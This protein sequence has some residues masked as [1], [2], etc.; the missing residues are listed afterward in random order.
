MSMGDAKANARCK[1]SLRPIYS[2]RVL[3]AFAN[4]GDQSQAS[5]AINDFLMEFFR[6]L[7]QT[8]TVKIPLLYRQKSSK[9]FF[10]FLERNIES[11]ATTLVFLVFHNI[12]IFWVWV[13]SELPGYLFMAYCC[14][15]SQVTFTSVSIK[16]V[17]RCVSV[18][19]VFMCMSACV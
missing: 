16:C 15:L 9:R 19:Y 12:N 8:F 6:S 7:S 18:Q 14:R 1:Q 2:K 17:G 10:L 5:N 13:V 3:C 4:D 11:I